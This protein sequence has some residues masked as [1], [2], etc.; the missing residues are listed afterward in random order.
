MK[1][2]LNKKNIKSRPTFKDDSDIFDDAD[3][4]DSLDS[5]DD[6]YIRLSTS[7][8]NDLVKYYFRNFYSF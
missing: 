6:N 3:K 5:L 2:H 7:E 4:V 8:K 1:D